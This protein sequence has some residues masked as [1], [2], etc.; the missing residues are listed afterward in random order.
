[1]VIE[2]GLKRKMILKKMGEN[3][4]DKKRQNNNNG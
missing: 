2:W 3:K 4:K 1:M